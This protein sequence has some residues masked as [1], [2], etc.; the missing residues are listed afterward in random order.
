MG[1]FGIEFSD[2]NNVPFKI[3]KKRHYGSVMNAGRDLAPDSSFQKGLAWAS[4][5][6]LVFVALCVF[7]KPAMA[8]VFENTSS[9]LLP[10]EQKIP[11]F[12]DTKKWAL[13]ETVLED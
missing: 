9:L 5:Y 4:Y 12:Q 6:V 10:V 8:G 3:L 13:R 7:N 2:K 1:R 11:E